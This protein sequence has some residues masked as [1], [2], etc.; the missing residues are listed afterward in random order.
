MLH[1]NAPAAQQSTTCE[2]PSEPQFNI[3]NA[4]RVATADLSPTLKGCD[5]Q[6]GSGFSFVG[7]GL[8]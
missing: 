4:T 5:T 2:V 8:V 6:Q 7:L 1:T 3:Q